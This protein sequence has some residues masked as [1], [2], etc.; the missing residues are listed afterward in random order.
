MLRTSTW[1]PLFA[2]AGGHAWAVKMAAV[3]N[4]L[5]AL[6]ASWWAGQWLR[7]AGADVGRAAAAVALPLLLSFALAPVVHLNYEGW[8][9]T[10]FVLSAGLLVSAPARDPVPAIAA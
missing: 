8:Y 1:W 6:L 3:G 5:A 7:R 10:A 4:L 9:L 2:A